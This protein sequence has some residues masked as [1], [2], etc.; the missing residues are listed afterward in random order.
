M[1]K[2][3]ALVA[4]RSWQSVAAAIALLA[5]ISTSARAQTTGYTEIYNSGVLTLGSDESLR[6][7]IVN[8]NNVSDPALP[9]LPASEEACACVA[10]F[11]DGNGNVLQKEEQT[12]QPGQN[13]SFTQ[14]GQPTVQARVDISPGTSSGFAAGVAH[15]CVVSTEIVNTASDDLLLFAPL[16]RSVSPS[17]ENICERSCARDCAYLCRPIPSGVRR[18]CGQCNRDCRSNCDAR[19]DLGPR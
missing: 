9:N 6:V 16:S 19:D 11:L 3:K 5:A 8:N 18:A 10:L 17:P 4:R 2:S 1:H 13:F 7:T 12:L 15:Q 14:S